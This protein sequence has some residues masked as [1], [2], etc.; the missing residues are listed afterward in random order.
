MARRENLFNLR[1]I[2]FP[3]YL[4]H[5]SGYVFLTE[6]ERCIK[7]SNYVKE[8]EYFHVYTSEKSYCFPVRIQKAG[9]LF[10]NMNERVTMINTLMDDE[11]VKMNRSLT[12]RYKL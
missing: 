11:R 1:I 5:F 9:I 8:S 10:P 2:H 12:K 4:F 6:R 7:F 3:V